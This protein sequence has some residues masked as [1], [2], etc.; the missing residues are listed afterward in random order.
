MYKT[1]G[2]FGL[3]VLCLVL[4]FSP[5]RSYAQVADLGEI[6]FPTS[7]APAAQQHFVRGVL[8]LHS[9]EYKD[10]EEAFRMAQE[11]DP[12]FAMAYWGEA[13]THNHPIWNQQDRDAALA[14]LRRFGETSEARLDKTPTRREKDYLA[15]L[16]VL[17]AEGDKAARD[18]AYSEE[19]KKLYRQ[20]PDDLEAAAF[21]ALS[22]LGTAQGVRDFRVYMR[23]GAIAQEVFQ[24]NPK[25]PGAA[26]YVIHSFDD[27]IHAPLGLP[28]ARVYA[29]IAPDAPHALH[30]PS[31]I[32]MALGMWDESVASNKASEAAAIKKGQSGLHASW[33][34]H[35]S[36]LQQGRHADA[37]AWLRLTRER[38][39]PD[40]GASGKRH[41]AYM[42]AAHLIETRDRTALEITEVQP[43]EL[44]ARQAT[45]LLSALGLL[46]VEQGKL[47]E[48]GEVL[49]V[50]RRTMP[51]AEGEDEE[52]WLHIAEQ[53]LVA[54]LTRAEGQADEAILLL[55]KAVEY[56]DGLTYEFGPPL[57]AKP[58][59]ELLGEM[60]LEVGR[61]AEARAAFRAS[62]SRNANRA[63][64][65]LGLARASAAEGDLRA[66]KL[67]Y[68]ELSRIWHGADA[69]ILELQEVRGA[70]LPLGRK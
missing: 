40:L 2:G 35:Y 13:M 46:S 27:P 59:H 4:I 21:Y 62:L 44:P 30:M 12:N 31:H 42:S 34:L 29:A 9:F 23:A 61:F 47:T 33:W 55:Q 6:R 49:G 20:Y 11:L 45:N 19:M 41:L 32:F 64:S 43:D 57:P 25:H 69:A 14:V 66:S 48:A 28:A 50:L 38:L 8:F 60:L 24:K 63:F 51:A 39:E 37:E 5:L 3:V 53:E 52:G 70:S 15:T 17:Y 7:G 56:Q 58:V 18:L 36:L 65:L 68:E 16:D 22:I 10:A 54:A 26:H 1:R 67:A